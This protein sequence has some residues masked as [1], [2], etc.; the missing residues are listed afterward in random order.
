MF[1]RV[2]MGVQLNLAEKM[3]AAS[4]PWQELG[5]LYVEDFPVIVSLL[6]DRSR[7]KDFQII[8]ACFCQI[9]EVQHPTNPNGIPVLKTNYKSLPKFL[10]NR[11]A[12]DDATK[13][14]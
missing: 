3:R 14:Q 7:A 8:L 12:L 2:Q 4:G 1:A 6:K 5:K 9:L 11:E 10:D 13:S